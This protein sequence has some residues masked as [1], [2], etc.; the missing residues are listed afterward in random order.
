MQ[1]G[2]PTEWYEYPAYFSQKSHCFRQEFDKPER[3]R[4]EP[5]TVVH[6][7]TVCPAMDACRGRS[8]SPMADF[9]TESGFS[10][11]LYG[12][13]VWTGKCL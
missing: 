4:I 1:G 6:N 10:W 12:V 7:R 5:R 2:G 13:F 3:G 11:Y 9:I 8:V